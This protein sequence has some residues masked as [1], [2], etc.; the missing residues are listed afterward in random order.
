VAAVVR[1]FVR[2]VEVMNEDVVDDV[3][4]ALA[5]AVSAVSRGLRRVDDTVGE[6]PVARALGRG[7]D[8]VVVRTGLDD[9]RRFERVRTGLVLGMVALLGLVVLSSVV[10]G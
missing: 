5:S 1:F 8:E 2:S 4:D 3:F 10:L 9:P 7:A 6:G